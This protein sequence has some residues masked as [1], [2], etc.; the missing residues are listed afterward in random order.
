MNKLDPM[1]C[2]AT[3][4]QKQRQCGNHAIPGGTV[5]RNH[6]G[7]APQ[8]KRKA[9]ER[10]AETRDNALEALNALIATGAIDA[11]TALDAVVKLT[12]TTE[13][14]AGRVARREEHVNVS[15]VD[16]ELQRLADELRSR[17]SS[18]V[19]VATDSPT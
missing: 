3:S 4:K 17:A 12:E 14:L 5:C 1:R 15:E 13:T 11:K 8:V 16:R 6:G 19:Q 7:S 10:L 2:T 9:A 18:P